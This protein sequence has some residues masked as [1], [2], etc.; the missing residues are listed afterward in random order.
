MITSN[1]SAAPTRSS[2]I[3]RSS[4]AWEQ[5]LPQGAIDGI[6]VIDA[7]S[8]GLAGFCCLRARRCKS[9]AAITHPATYAQA[10][11]QQQV[12]PLASKAFDGYQSIPQQK[13]QSFRYLGPYQQAQSFYPP[14]ASAVSPRPTAASDSRFSSA[15][16]NLPSYSPVEP[17]KGKAVTFARLRSQK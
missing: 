11:R 9:M 12:Q 2:A 17:D 3:P 15:N 1:L 6:A 4:T 7:L 5:W 8:L 10:P 13:H 14:L 16:T